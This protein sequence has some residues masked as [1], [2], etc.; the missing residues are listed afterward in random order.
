MEMFQF[1]ITGV[2]PLLMNNPASMGG[3]DNGLKSG[4]KKYDPE[5]EAEARLYRNERSELV[6]PTIAF[7]SALFRAG[8]SRKIGKV[9]AKTVI[10][11]AVF[12]VEQECI[13]LDAK[14]KKPR[15]DY[16]I[17]ACRAVVN[18]AGIIRHRP[19]IKDW[20]LDLALEI[21]T[22]LL[23][24]PTVVEELLNI[25]GKIVGVLDWRPQKLGSFGRFTAELR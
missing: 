20:A 15:K 12:P 11:G 25:A 18:N 6:V 23:P 21:D 1:R 5:I 4:K 17:H 3:S 10:A 7:R 22:E 9:A 14:S 16:E 13:I 24:E 2:S 8:T 19:M